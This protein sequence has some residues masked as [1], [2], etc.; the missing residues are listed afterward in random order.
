MK[1]GILGGGQLGRMLALAG[2]PLGL[3]FRHLDLSPAAPAGPLGELVTGAYD[4]AE[5]LDD[6]AADLD[7]VTYEFENV[8]VGTAQRIARLKDVL[9][10]PLALEVAQDRLNEKQLFAKLGVPTA[11]YAAVSS[12]AE[13]DGALARI[14]TP[15]LL[16][17]RRFG[18]D[19]KGQARINSPADARHAYDAI[20]GGV[21][22]L[23]GYVRFDRE[24]SIVSV[25]GRTGEIRH[26]PLV[27][28]EH[29]RGILIQTL[30]PAADVS[31]EMQN[32]AERVAAAVLEE[33]GY[34]GVLAIELFQ[35]GDTLLANE[36]APRVHNSGHWTIEGAET[37]QFENHL[38]AICG[39]PLGSTAAVGACAMLNLI[40]GVP[41]PGAVLGVPGAHLHLYGKR[42]R[43]GRKLGHVT[44]HAETRGE[45]AVRLGALAPL[46]AAA[47][48]MAEG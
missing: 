34:V 38:R 22:L 31:A 29:H 12:I 41:D 9:P 23:E 6:F 5:L 16:K 19:G 28:N 42:P 13:L 46:V 1:I 3:H 39:Y 21:L 30:A 40:G 33:L 25:R 36:M 43:P 8:P 15:A 14:G 11:P 4:D 44:V 17:T 7:I 37:S 35:D 27:Q 45:L 47:G 20:G 32:A 24:L 18:Y 2:Y 10:P 26:Y 48:V